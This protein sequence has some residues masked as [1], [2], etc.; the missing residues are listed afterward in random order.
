[1]AF[2]I[3]GIDEDEYFVIST[4]V[5]VSLFT[6]LVL[7]PL[8]LC[9]LCVVALLLATIINGKIILL[10][11]NILAAEI[12][13]WI[14]YSVF[15]LG[16]PARIADLPGDYSCQFFTSA[17]VVVAIQKFTAA[18]IYAIMVYIFI[19]HGERKLKWYVVIPFIFGSW[20]L[21][22]ATMGAIPLYR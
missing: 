11:V 21:V 22:I 9:L 10:L 7:P 13:N 18:A 19:K 16:F 20:I 12:C 2:N 3:T 1:M 4:V 17:F 6:I 15:Y 8:I 14:S 5:N